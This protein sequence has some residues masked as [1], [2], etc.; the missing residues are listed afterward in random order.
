M[1]TKILPI[2]LSLLLLLSACNLP[3]GG[4][5]DAAAQVQTAAAETVSAQLTQNSALTPSATNTPLPTAT[6]AATNTP[7]ITNT[8]VPTSASSG[9]GSAGG[10]CDAIAFLSDVTVP[11][12][13]DF[14]PDATF[15]KTWR[16]RNAGTC[17]WSTAYSVVFSSG[18]SMGGPATQALTANVTPN[19]TIDISV[20][21][22]APSTNGT[23][24]GYW[25][26]RNASGQTFG[27]F[28]VVIDVV[29]GGSSGG[30]GSG[31][32]KV[33]PAAN[34]GQVDASGN[35]GSAP[36]AGSLSDV[37]VRAFVSFDISSI[38]SGAT[39]DSV[40]V[41]FSGFDTQGNPFSSMGC[42]QAYAGTYFALD[43]SDY[44]ASGAGPDMSWCSTGEL[45]TVFENDDVRARLQAALGSATTL[46]YQLRFSGSPTG[47]SQVRFL[48]GGMKLIVSYTE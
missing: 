22:K 25:A 48:N 8:P 12:G 11:D 18:N 15:T 31:S 35:V 27:S 37:G 28:Y 41:D 4:G 26:L 42:L 38:P 29:S 5:E 40:S 36:N 21:L 43:A 10:G 30:S 47:S 34:I 3:G 24:T 2:A 16:I 33:F 19:S 17:T 44:S 46:Q 45:S 32:G 14:A 7:G 6:Q 20:N 23:Y 39:I 9:G 1:R 13:T